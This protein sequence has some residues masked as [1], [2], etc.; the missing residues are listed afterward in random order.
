M[1]ARGR[2]PIAG[3]LGKGLRRVAPFPAKT[4]WSPAR[5]RNIFRR[6][7]RRKTPGLGGSTRPRSRRCRT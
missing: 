6:V 5:V 3:G 2:G 7:G 1:A 4:Q